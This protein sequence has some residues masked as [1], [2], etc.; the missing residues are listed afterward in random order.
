MMNGLK[1]FFKRNHSQMVSQ[2]LSQILNQTHSQKPTHWMSP[3]R[4]PI[5]ISIISG[6][7]VGTSYIPF[8]PWAIFF[9]YVPLWLRVLKETS[10][11]RVFWLGW[12]TQFVLTLIGFHWIAYTAHEFGHFP[13]PFAGLTLF[14][15]AALAHLYIPLSIVAAIHLRNWTRLSDYLTLVVLALTLIFSERFWPS[16]FPWNLGYTFLWSRWPL[17]QWADMIGFEGLSALVLL[18]NAGVGITWLRAQ[19]RPRALLK[20]ALAIVVGLGLLTALG[21]SHGRGWQ[22]FDSSVN[23]LSVQGNIGNFEKIAAEKGVA[24]QSDILN[25]FLDLTR[26]GL[27][28]HPETDL[29]LWPE[30]AFPDFLDEY[31]QYRERPAR[32]REAVRTW[33]RP[34]LTG[35]FSKDHLVFDTNK[36]TFNA[37]FLISKDG[38][39]LSPPY[40]KTY[41]LAFG[42]YLPFSERFPILLKWITLV[43]NFGRGTGP[44]VFSWPRTLPENSGAATEVL[45]LGPQICYEGLYPDFSR[46]LV[47]QGADLLANFTN[48]SWFGLNLF[49][50]RFE[51]LQ[52]MTMTL[53]RGIEFRRPVVRA[54][55]TGISTGILADGTILQQSPIDQ[56]W[57]GLLSVKYKKNASLTFFA[58]YGNLDSWVYLFIFFAILGLN[59]NEKRRSLMG[60]TTP[61]N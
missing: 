14:A 51:P 28:K 42:E 3:V 9:A 1:N 34:L 32:L 58:K 8:Q 54:T 30:T 15:F 37:A 4:G 26:L 6:L 7:L 25:R 56:P 43:S 39:H 38:V 10:L 23:I 57:T 52:H 53:G 59:W 5:L 27:Q 45:K 17:Y 47:Q 61:Q 13:W 60:T 36:N 16:L 20:L 18:L 24:F 44:A 55:N 21:V 35:A 50:T 12:I 49:G 11:V 31:Y 46:S 41:L 40:H 19:N 33:Q 2:R 48:D 22:E 29:I